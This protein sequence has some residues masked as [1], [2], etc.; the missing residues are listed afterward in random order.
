MTVTKV[1]YCPA[2]F[3]IIVL[4]EHVAT[5]PDQRLPASHL[6]RQVDDEP[7]PGT[8]LLEHQQ[9]TSD[10][11]RPPIM[12]W[13]TSVVPAFHNNDDHSI[14]SGPGSLLFATTFHQLLDYDEYNDVEVARVTCATEEQMILVT[15]V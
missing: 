8:G 4:Q 7:Y 9:D 15:R 12:L 3:T 5:R 1:R 14:S 13:L 10:R 2:S 6:T 11:P